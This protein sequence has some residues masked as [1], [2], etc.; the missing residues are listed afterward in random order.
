M[1]DNLTYP[2]SIN[3]RVDGEMANYLD[4]ACLTPEYQGRRAEF[5]RNIIKEYMENHPL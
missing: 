5:L 2:F 3:F 4:K 1:G